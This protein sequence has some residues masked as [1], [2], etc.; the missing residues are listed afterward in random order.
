MI[1]L[2]SALDD[3][4]RCFVV[5]G[6]FN[7]S[8]S[9]F[10]DFV[11]RHRLPAAVD[12]SSAAAAHAATEPWPTETVPV[13]PSMVLSTL[14][15]DKVRQRRDCW[16]DLIF[17]S[18]WPRCSVVDCNVSFL[19]LSVLFAFTCTLFLSAFF[20]VS[21]ACSSCIVFACRWCLLVGCL[22]SLSFCRGAVRLRLCFARSFPRVVM[23]L[24]LLRVFLSVLLA[25]R[26]ARLLLR[27]SS[28][29]V[30][31]FSLTHTHTH[32]CDS[33]SLAFC[34][35]HIFLALSFSRALSRSLFLACS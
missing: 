23:S 33:R 21:P 14:L 7:N 35:S 1:C 22:V 31:S 2:C 34:F 4:W 17:N 24:L 18:A 11:N 16:W 3:E 15:V 30:V 26:T 32:S 25:R 12:N 13:C 10:I 9:D 6:L 5:S 28:L 27:L 19:H 20:V 8:H 29:C